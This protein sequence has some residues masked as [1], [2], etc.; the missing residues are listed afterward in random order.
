MSLSCESVRKAIPLPRRQRPQKPQRWS[1][2]AHF[3]AG[4]CGELIGL[5]MLMDPS[6]WGKVPLHLRMSWVQARG[7]GNGQ[8]I[9][10]AAD[11]ITG[12]ARQQSEA[13]QMAGAE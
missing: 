11:A 13:G 2:T 4:G 6:C 7:S 5:S 3:C 10:R 12:Y 1:G 9:E 8:A